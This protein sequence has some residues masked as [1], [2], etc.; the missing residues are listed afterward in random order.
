VLKH[1]EA[2][3]RCAVCKHLESEH[4]TSGTRPCLS[5][6]GDLLQREFCACDHFQAGMTMAA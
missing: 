6:V 5:M 2:E 1:Q 4:G 3:V